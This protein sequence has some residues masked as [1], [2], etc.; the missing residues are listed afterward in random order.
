MDIRRAATAA[1]D[2]GLKR[3]SLKELVHIVK[4]PCRDAGLKAS[5]DRHRFAQ[6]KREYYN[7]VMDL[8]EGELTRCKRVIRKRR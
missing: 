8:L 1:I 6:L 7:M 3:V 2:D 4:V 5:R